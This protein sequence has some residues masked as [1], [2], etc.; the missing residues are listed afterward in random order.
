MRRAEDSVE[1]WLLPMMGSESLCSAY[2]SDSDV[3]AI[4][5]FASRIV[6]QLV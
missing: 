2:C 4:C 1:P 6:S 5:G 3:S